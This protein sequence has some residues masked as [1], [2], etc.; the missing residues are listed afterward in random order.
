MRA[1]ILAI[2]ILTLVI[3][4]GFT[5][6]SAAGP[7]ILG[8]LVQVSGTSP[9]AGCTAD[10]VGG[11][12]GTNVLHS[13]VEPWIAVNPATPSNIV[14]IWQ[15]DRWSN[16]GARGH[17]AGVSTNGGTTWTMV[18]IPGITKCS[19]GSYDR[20]TDPWVSFGP[21]GTVHQL[22]LSFND[23]IS[24]LTEGPGGDFDHALLYSRSTNGG[25]TWSAPVE[26]IRDLDANVFNDKQSITA[27]PFDS[28][29]IYAVWDRLVFPASERASIIAGFVTLAFRGPAW[30]ARTTDGG[31]TWEEARLIYDPG[32][33][34]QTI[35]NQI[36]V[37]PS[38]HL[39]NVF[40]LITPTGGAMRTG[41]FYN[42]ALVRST[43]RG[44]TWGPRDRN[45]EV[46]PIVVDA[47]RTVFVTDPESGDDVRTG[48]IIPDVAVAP[49]GHLYVVW[50]D[51]RPNGLGADAV[52]VSRSTDGGLTWS[53][54]VKVNKTPT[55]IPIGNQ[56]AFTPS[57]HVAADGT[58]AV[59]YYDFRFN[60][61]GSDLKTDYWIVHC[62][63][64][65]TVSCTNPLDWTD[66]V[67]L[68]AASFD[69]RLA[70]F[71]RGF[72]TGDYEGLASAGNAFA[73]FWSQSHAA[74]PASVF[75]RQAAP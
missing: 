8:G 7:F 58:V 67:R 50:Q 66:E 62:H 40:D 59:T 73:P 72:F 1:A 22:S 74:D 70:P 38:G 54:F 18:V 44:E 43:D 12:S 16:G 31:A 45:G 21:T 2:V 29:Y 51:A 69:M 3:P 64:G 20:A 53:P 55:N 56:Q 24:P 47:L 65:G 11:Q 33:R 6:R 37:L 36:A 5:G 17:V 9:F 46:A 14:G 63:A 39:V 4:F 28:N 10:N 26:V 42:V 49:N 15:Q 68:T 34:K 27:D 61:G 19:G 48:D 57:V 32:V 52:V 13:E 35:G 30:F 23:L 75:F 71:A 41:A 60:D 25:M